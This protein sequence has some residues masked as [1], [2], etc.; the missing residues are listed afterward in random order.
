MDPQDDP[1]EQFDAPTPWYGWLACCLPWIVVVVLAIFLSGCYCKSAKADTKFGVHMGSIHFAGDYNNF[2]P[3]VYV[4]HDGWTG[5]VY[6]NSE[7][8]VSAYAGYTFATG[9]LDW[10]LG[11][12]TGYERA[13]VLPL[14]APSVAFNFTPEVAGRVVL[15]PNPFKPKESALHFTLEWSL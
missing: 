4:N 10:T 9:P 15:L 1:R 8:R 3:G 6:Y 7:R 2:N 5:G 13:R 11:A 14:V 12:I